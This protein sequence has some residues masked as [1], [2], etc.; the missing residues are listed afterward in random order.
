MPSDAA[1]ARPSHGPPLEAYLDTAGSSGPST[2]SPIYS[3]LADLYSRKLFY[4]LLITTQSFFSHVDSAQGTLRYDLFQNFIVHWKGKVADLS[5]A[6]LVTEAAKQLKEPELALAFI[7]GQRDEMPPGSPP[8][9]LLSMEATYHRLLLGQ[10]EDVRKEVDA[11]QKVLNG[12]DAVD[13]VVSGGFYRVAAEY[14]KAK[15]MYQQ[16]YTSSLLYLA[17]LPHSG[18]GSD[19]TESEK[20]ERA[21]DLAIAAILGQGIWN[22]GE[23]LLHP[24]LP[25]LQSTGH[26]YLLP[27]LS[28]F[29]SG[30]LPLFD[31]L[32][33]SIQ[34]HPLL[35][36]SMPFL[37]QKICLMALIESVSKRDA[38]Q[39]SQLS[40]DTIA[41]ETGLPGDEV[42]H[43]C[44]K[45]LSL[46]LIRG[47]LDQASSLAHIEWVQPRVLEMDQLR[48]L[49]T[50]LDSWLGRVDETAQFV[51]SCQEGSSVDQTS[52]RTAGP[53]QI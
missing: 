18:T 41:K 50:K 23:L 10:L 44:M 7:S 48:L 43:L 4:Q 53:V 31:S 11:G 25:V 12:Y 6:E 14:Y 24:L 8:H 1:G 34:S 52:Q 19:L 30:S 15:A 35:A 46:S 37:R 29:S 39:R 40:F 45:A 49:R 42:E 9:L 20:V 47:S 13:N 38:R 33:P 27:L 21:H 17:C 28:S 26:A 2:L 22:F 3:E 36:P 16:Y 32:L 51:R 5:I